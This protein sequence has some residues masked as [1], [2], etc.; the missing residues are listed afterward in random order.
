MYITE[1]AK[2]RTQ[3]IKGVSYVYE[4]YVNRRVKGGQYQRRKVG[5]FVIEKDNG[6]FGGYSSPFRIRFC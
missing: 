5:H 2:W 1:S 3:V 4:D 6:S